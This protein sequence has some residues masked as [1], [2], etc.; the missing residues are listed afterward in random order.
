MDDLTVLD[1]QVEVSCKI[2]YRTCRHDVILTSKNG[3]GRY[4]FRCTRCHAAQPYDPT[5]HRDLGP[6]LGAK[7]QPLRRAMHAKRWWTYASIACWVASAAYLTR[8]GWPIDGTDA[9]VSGLLFGFLI[10][11]FER[12]RP[13]R[14]ANMLWA[15]ALVISGIL[16]YRVGLHHATVYVFCLFTSLHVAQFLDWCYSEP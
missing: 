10:G 14:N 3:A 1:V 7:T 15:V 9:C 12:R 5:I 2:C 11:A 16:C 13:Q 6:L 8:H 4:T